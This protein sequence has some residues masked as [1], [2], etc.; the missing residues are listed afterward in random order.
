MEN[1]LTKILTEKI[2]VL[3][4]EVLDPVLITELPSDAL[5]M[6]LE[7]MEI[8]EALIEAEL[9]KIK[10]VEEK[11]SALKKEANNY[12]GQLEEQL[13]LRLKNEVKLVSPNQIS[14]S[15]KTN[16]AVEVIDMEKLPGSCIRIKKEADKTMIKTLIELGEIKEDVAKLTKSFSVNRVKPKQKK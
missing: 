10:S 5:P 13:K 4:M 15:L 7:H 9:A 14:Y 2:T 8:S 6:V 3:K 1:I 11:L 12:L 16:A